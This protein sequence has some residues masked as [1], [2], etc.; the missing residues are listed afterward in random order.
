MRLTKK[1][2]EEI[3][4][5]ILGEEGL[6]LVKELTDKENVSEFELA[7]KI[8]KDIKV[9]RRMLYLLYNHNLICF[10]RKKD[11]Q[12]GWYIYYWTLIPESIRFNYFKRKKELLERLKESLN[13]ENKELF[14]VCPNNCVRLNF[15][16]SM[17]FEFHCP[18]CGELIS[19]DNSKE[20]IKMLQKDIKDIEKELEAMKIRRNVR[21]KKVKERKKEVKTKKK[22]VKKTITKKSVKKKAPAT[23]KS[24]KSIKKIKPKKTTKIVA[25]KKEVV[26]KKKKTIKEK[27]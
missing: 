21:R 10:T 1:K 20:R 14:F 16:Q 6:P 17:D 15:D 23:K 25:K 18:E 24:V 27:K 5:S 3:M 4:L 19:Q 26:K 9:V 8:K 12:K 22:I 7:D 11:K 2:I 13:E